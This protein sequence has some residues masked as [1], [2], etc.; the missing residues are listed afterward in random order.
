MATVETN[1]GQGR[2]NRWAS[3]YD[4]SILQR[5][6]FEPV[7]DAVLSAFS[8]HSAPPR[9]VLDVGCGTGRLLETCAGRWNGVRFRGID[10]SAEMIAE[11][12]RKHEG[13]ARYVFE[14]GDASALQLESDSFDA[15]FS[16]MSFHHWRDQAAGIREI[17]RVLRP[18]GLFVLAD[19]DPP[20]LSLWRSFIKRSGHAFFMGPD[21]IRRL[22]EQAGLSVVTRRRFWPL[23]R[24]QLLVTRKGASSA[25][26]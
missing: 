9:D 3:S 14:Q 5:L 13:D 18:G 17:A 6:M 20:F 2:F 10:A 21:A 24:V 16:T 12:R 26:T 4:R 1:P 7:H 8:A 25:H 11:A 19:V 15:A 22:V 23:L